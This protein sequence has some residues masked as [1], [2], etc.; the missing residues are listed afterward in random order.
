MAPWRGRGAEELL[1]GLGPGALKRIMTPQA[2]FPI[3]IIKP[4]TESDPTLNG[5][6]RVLTGLQMHTDLIVE[7]IAGQAP[8]PDRGS[9][10]QRPFQPAIALRQAQTGSQEH[11][12]PQTPHLKFTGLTGGQQEGRSLLW[13]AERLEMIGKQIERR[14]LAP[15]AGDRARA[16][17]QGDKL[18]ILVLE[19][20]QTEQGLGSAFMLQGSG[21]GPPLLQ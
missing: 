8:G 6:G 5:L 7:K 10:F 4:L 9:L 20:S 15:G 16:D 13:T 21:G 18:E 11:A 1:E 14:P 17:R 19:R 2:P 3:G 12:T